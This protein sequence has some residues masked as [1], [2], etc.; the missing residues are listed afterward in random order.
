[1][2]KSFIELVIL[3]VSIL[4]V[5]GAIL[6]VCITTPWL[7]HREI[8][9]GF[10]KKVTQEQKAGT[11]T[12]RRRRSALW[13]EI[14]AAAAAAAL[15]LTRPLGLRLFARP[16]VDAALCACTAAALVSIVDFFVWRVRVRWGETQFTYVSLFR[17]RHKISYA[18]ILYYRVG[19]RDLT[20]K[21]SRGTYRAGTRAANA[22]VLRAALEENR[23]ESRA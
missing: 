10:Y 1:M 5:Y 3:L 2:D 18:D 11:V 19:Y 17:G 22:N 15:W 8:A 4:A 6:A 21:T 16:A 23:V 7:R 20:V 13:P 12:V 14:A 9:P